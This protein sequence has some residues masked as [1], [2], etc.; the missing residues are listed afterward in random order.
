MRC[1]EPTDCLMLLVNDR[2]ETFFAVDL[3]RELV[4]RRFVCPPDILCRNG[5]WGRSHDGRQI[6]ATD[7][8]QRELLRL[9]AQTGA[10]VGTGVAGPAW[11]TVQ[12]STETSRGERIVTGMVLGE[13]PEGPTS[14]EFTLMRVGTDGTLR[15]LWGSERTWLARPR[16]SPDGRHVALEGQAFHAEL[17][18][19][20]LGSLCDETAPS[21]G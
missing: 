13:P 21:R 14:D 5:R 11:A 1:R 4:R 8:A 2:I 20:E 19:I 12:A 17:V 7:Q 16:A 3:E 6:L 9:D 10:R 18:A 15:R